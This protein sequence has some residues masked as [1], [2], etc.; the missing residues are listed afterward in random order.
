MSSRILIALGCRNLELRVNDSALQ[1]D[2][3]YGIDS[4]TG[5]CSM[6]DLSMDVQFVSLREAIWGWF[7]AMQEDEN[8]KE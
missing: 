3:D 1:W 4:R 6:Y 8:G 5:W 7:E 2:A